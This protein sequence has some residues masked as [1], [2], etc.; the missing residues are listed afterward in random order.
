LGKNVGVDTFSNRNLKNTEGL[1]QK[2][3]TVDNSYETDFYTVDNLSS[4]AV[5]GRTSTKG[6]SSGDP[7][8]LC[9]L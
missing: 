7:R 5:G 8:I 1:R 6:C 4:D 2:S 3:L 9:L